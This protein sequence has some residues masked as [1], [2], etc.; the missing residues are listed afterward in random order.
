MSQDCIYNTNHCNIV[1]YSIRWIRARCVVD[2]SARVRWFDDGR[3]V[4]V[5]AIGDVHPSPAQR[6]EGLPRSEACSLATIE[7]MRR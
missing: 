7:G 6:L 5:T 3:A 2:S 4:G 1:S